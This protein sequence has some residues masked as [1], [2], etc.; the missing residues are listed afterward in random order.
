M[1]RA[2]NPCS[3][4]SMRARIAS[5]ATMTMWKIQAL[6]ARR[7]DTAASVLERIGPNAV[8]HEAA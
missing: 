7:Y 3:T 8:S 2:A 4:A 5:R 1:R 6:A